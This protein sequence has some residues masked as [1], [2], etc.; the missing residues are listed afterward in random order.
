V[1][2][3]AHVAELCSSA[4]GTIGDGTV[5]VVDVDRLVRIRIDEGGTS[6]VRA[7]MRM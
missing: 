3:Q 7:G 4:S 2:P 6:A 5:W 1:H